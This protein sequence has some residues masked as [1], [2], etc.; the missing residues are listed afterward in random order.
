MGLVSVQDCNL[1]FVESSMAA[2]NFLQKIFGSYRVSAH[3]CIVLCKWQFV[4]TI[5]QHTKNN[6]EALINHALYELC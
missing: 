1:A 4:A 2:D 5:L 6:V 3:V